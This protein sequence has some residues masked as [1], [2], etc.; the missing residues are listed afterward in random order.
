M[1][2]DAD[3]PKLENI[4]K[5]YSS[6]MYQKPAYVEVIPQKQME[7]KSRIGELI[8]K[9]MGFGAEEAYAQEK[10]Y[11]ALKPT[12]PMDLV[13]KIVKL[14]LEQGDVIDVNKREVAVNYINKFKENLEELKKYDLTSLDTETR[15]TLS[16]AYGNYGLSFTK[17]EDNENLTKTDF[18][19]AKEMYVLSSKL[20]PENTNNLLNLGFHYYKREKNYEEALKFYE[21]VLEIKPNEMMAKIFK[22]KCLKKLK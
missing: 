11:G 2:L 13:E 14:Y 7:E 15:D 22:R 21:K 16:N 4:A 10:A 12:P 19:K 1:P 8:N 3:L 20:N 17:Y 5:A 6:G 9:I 18:E